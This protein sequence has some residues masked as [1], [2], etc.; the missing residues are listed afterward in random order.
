LHVVFECHVKARENKPRWCQ[1]SAVPEIV[2][3]VRLNV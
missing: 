1:Q 2:L 3:H